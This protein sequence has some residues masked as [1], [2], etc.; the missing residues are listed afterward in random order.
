MTTISGKIRHSR[1]ADSSS[2]KGGV[3][4]EYMKRGLSGSLDRKGLC[5]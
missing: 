3:S 1:V 2:Y 4:D 5:T